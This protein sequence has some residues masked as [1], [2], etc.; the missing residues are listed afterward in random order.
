MNHPDRTLRKLRHPDGYVTRHVAI[1]READAHIRALAERF[2]LSH[3]AVV[4]AM[5]LAH[6]AYDLPVHFP[7]ASS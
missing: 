6:R 5:V 4:N 2:R 7:E 1:D 3:S